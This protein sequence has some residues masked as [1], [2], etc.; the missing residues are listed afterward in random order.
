MAK[1]KPTRIN[2]FPVGPGPGLKARGDMPGLLFEEKRPGD[3]AGTPPGPDDG[4]FAAL[5]GLRDRLREKQRDEEF[6]LREGLLRAKKE[7]KAARSLAAVPEPQGEDDSE[8]GEALFLR[9]MEG[10]SPL[11]DQNRRREAEPLPAQSWKPTS[12]ESEDIAVLRDLAD[13]VSGKSEF[14]FSSTDELSEAQVKGLPAAVMEHLRQGR[15]PVQDH[16]DLHGLTLPEA[17]EAITR[18]VTDSVYLRRTCLLLVHGRGHRSPDGIPIIKRNLER[19]LLKSPIKKHILA[20]TTA[21]PMDGG[22]GASYI[23]LRG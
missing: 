15:I 18:F 10:V 1:P 4:P 23:L 17:E 11:A 9:A 5:A 22:S 3:L 16:L 19:L 7:R 12:S 20:F 14:D 6:R 21:R 13:L 8:D 2:G